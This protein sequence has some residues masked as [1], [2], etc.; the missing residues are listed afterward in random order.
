MSYNNN[1]P[2]V[3]ISGFK[4]G[5]WLMR[6]VLF[7]ITGMEFFEPEII[8]GEKKY[9]NP[10]QLQF[11]DN[12]FYSWH[13]VPTDEVVDKLNIN[14]AKTIFVVRNIYDLVISI[15]YHFYNN[16]DADIGRANNKDKFLKQFSFQEGLSLIITGFD[17]DGL[18]WSGMA[19]VLE[20]YNEIFKA[21]KKC[22][23]L[24]VNYDDLVSNKK[25]IINNIVD[26]LNISI[27]SQEIEDISNLTDFTSMKKEAQKNNVGSSHFREGKAGLNR[28]KLSQF[29]KVQLKQ[30]IKLITP[31]IYDNAKKIKKGSIVEF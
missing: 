19:E 25:V 10:A 22:D 7:S 5:T 27:T 15:Y 24:V 8:A 13:L 12:H 30:M 17:E 21:T 26:F 18:R 2:I 9:Y 6:K 28:E 29:H 1:E 14:N 20:H 4:A 31:D 11:V 3:L 23:S 16:I